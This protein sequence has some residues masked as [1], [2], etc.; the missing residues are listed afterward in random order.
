MMKMNKEFIWYEMGSG[1]RKEWN[2]THSRGGKKFIIVIVR[3]ERSVEVSAQNKIRK[4]KA[5]EWMSEWVNEMMG[6]ENSC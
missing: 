3:Y 1:R 5:N 4:N 2:S 6:K